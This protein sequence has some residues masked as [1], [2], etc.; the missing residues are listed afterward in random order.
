MTTV[1]VNMI[2]FLII[3]TTAVHVMSMMKGAEVVMTIMTNTVFAKNTKT[4]MVQW[5]V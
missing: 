1:M 4:V 3:M 2:S 5:Q